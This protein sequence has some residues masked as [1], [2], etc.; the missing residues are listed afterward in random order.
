MTHSCA[1]TIIWRP[2]FCYYISLIACLCCVRGGV[3]HLF[4]RPS[5]VQ[6]RAAGR[7]LK[8]WIQ[9]KTIAHKPTNRPHLAEVLDAVGAE[10]HEPRPARARLHALHAVVGRGVGP[11]EVHQHG[12]ALLHR[13]RALQRGDLVDLLGVVA[14]SVLLLLLLAL[15]VVCLA[16]ACGVQCVASSLV[17]LVPVVMAV[18]A[19]L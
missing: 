5:F 17:R 1:R 8:P 7:R 16:M 19:G 18:A 6:R 4:S 14:V 13:E 9:S 12:A 11:Q 2:F 10:R 15:C 3:E